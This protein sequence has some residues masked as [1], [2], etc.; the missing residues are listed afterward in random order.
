MI[1]ET[2]IALSILEIVALAVDE[3]TVD[4]GYIRAKAQLFGLRLILRA[5]GVHFS[6]HREVAEWETI[7][8]TRH[9]KDIR[10]MVS[11]GME[12]LIANGYLKYELM[13]AYKC[14]D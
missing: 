14:S 1:S 13:G 7:L 4:D 5:M 2:G 6:W 9:K 10:A 3:D 11:K 12:L 8:Q